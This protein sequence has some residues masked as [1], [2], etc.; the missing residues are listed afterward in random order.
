MLLGYK[1]W[2]GS[3]NVYDVEPLWSLTGFMESLEEV[4]KLAWS[5]PHCSSTGT[6]ALITHRCLFLGIRWE[7]WRCMVVFHLEQQGGTGFTSY[8]FI[9]ELVC[10]LLWPLFCWPRRSSF[11][12]C[13]ITLRVKWVIK[14]VSFFICEDC[15]PLVPRA[16]GRSCPWGFVELSQFDLWCVATGISFWLLTL[17]VTC[18]PLSNQKTTMGTV[19]NSHGFS[20]RMALWSTKV[21]EVILA[22]VWYSPCN[23]KYKHWCIWNAIAEEGVYMSIWLLWNSPWISGNLI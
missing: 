2:P 21:K 17:Y 15:I 18:L 12:T 10:V 7:G 1:T 9:H 13:L 3:G 5:I 20:G 8:E 22:I 19:D 6:Y 4:R 16:R 11:P 14:T 23:S